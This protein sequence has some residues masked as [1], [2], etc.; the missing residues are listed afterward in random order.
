MLY[1]GKDNL[2][3][4]PV[5][6]LGDKSTTESE[7]LQ[8]LFEEID[9]K[10][11]DLVS[12]NG[13]HFD[14]P[15]IRYRAMKNSLT[16]PKHWS[17]D[18]DYYHHDMKYELSMYNPDATG[19][20]D[21]IAKQLCFPGKMG[22]DGSKV[23]DEFQAGNLSDIRDYCETDVLN[24]YLIY[25]RYQLMSGEISHEALEQEFTLL[26][27]TLNSQSQNGQTHL[28]IFLKAW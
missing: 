10:K 22:M 18:S 28:G 8:L 14:M 1:R 19:P 16:L 7:L 24:T 23:W 26:R 11:P 27:D 15:V 3:L 25:L 21:H 6:S 4:E 5:K 2:I 20:L 13:S 12:W 9:N 17:E